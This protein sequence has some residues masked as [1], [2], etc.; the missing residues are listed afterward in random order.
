[1][2]FTRRRL[3]GVR[4][5]LLLVMLAL[6]TL[7]AACSAD[8]GVALTQW[9]LF[10]DGGV[11]DVGV[12]LPAHLDHNLPEKHVRFVLRARVELPASLR[13]RALTL[14]IPSLLARCTLDVDGVAMSALDADD[15][16]GYRGNGHPR[17]S[18]PAT[19]THERAIDLALTVDHTW[20]QSGWLDTAPRLSAT[21]AGDADYRRLR[22]FNGV[23]A[24]GALTAAIFVLFAYVILLAL[25]R[26]Q[27]AVRWFVLEGLTA[28][29]YP[30][31]NLGL[32]ASV[33]GI[34]DAPIMAVT[35][36]VTIWASVR[37]TH[38]QFKLPPP[39]WVW[40]LPLVISIV[41]ALLFP[42]PFDATKRVA[43]ITV[44]AVAL[45]VAY[46]LVVTARLA[47]VPEHAVH[48]RVLFISWTALGAT[49]I[50]DFAAWLGLGALAGG[51]RTAC[52]GIVIIAIL[53]SAVL[54]RDHVIALARAAVLNREIRDQLDH[55]ERKN[56]ENELLNGELRRQIAARTEHL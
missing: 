53:Q 19:R 2:C 8:E 48:A 15:S 39:H 40:H 36:V 28:T 3:P 54:S 47:R 44:A 41:A 20:T 16:D 30:A 31:F 9:R 6:S 32:T 55:V 5:A 18:I 17:W 50:V 7:V 43:P 13:D 52:V 51:A 27:R 56:A 12:T 11:Q 35:L 42:G 37:F 1:M 4:R 33:F 10:V 45:N 29:L 23:S 38:A 26:S 25:D 14:A 49:G 34:Y 46:Q 22:S 21:L 24:I